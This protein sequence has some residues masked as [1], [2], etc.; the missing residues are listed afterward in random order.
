MQILIAKRQRLPRDIVYSVC[1][2]SSQYRDSNARARSLSR[3]NA[4]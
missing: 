3:T 4:Y 1:H 2:A